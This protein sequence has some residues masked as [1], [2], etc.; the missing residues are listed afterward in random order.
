MIHNVKVKTSYHVVVVDVGS[1][2]L[3][4]IGW[5]V[6]DILN[7]CKYKGDNLEDLIGKLSGLLATAG[8]LFGL[9][10]PLCVPIRENIMD[11]TRAR[12]G[13]GRRP[14]SAG[15]G[16]QVLTMNLPIMVFLL[17]K[18]KVIKNTLSLFY[19]EDGFVGSPGELMFFE[20]LVSG[21]DKGKTHID[22]AEIM[23]DTC[24]QSSLQ[25]QLPQSILEMENT[26]EYFNLVVAAAMR[27]G[28]ENN[29]RM[30]WQYT[31]IYKPMRS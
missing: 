29:Q 26:T 30:L 3:G 16:A 19:N 13:E 12:K 10:A 24:I 21:V 5:C 4:N 22:D 17:K 14:W 9:E 20:A 11:A 31:P 2:K 8:V 18:L 7:G 23:V 15:A 6:F 27:A 1:P 25:K 28:F